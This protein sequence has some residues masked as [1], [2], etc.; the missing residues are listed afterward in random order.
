MPSGRL[1]IVLRA[2]LLSW[3][4][5]NQP[6]YFMPMTDRPCLLVR[7]HQPASLC[8]FGLEPW[9]SIVRCSEMPHGADPETHGLSFVLLVYDEG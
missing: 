1:F 2:A 6:S 9:P 4:R 7:S 8:F 3:L 5:S